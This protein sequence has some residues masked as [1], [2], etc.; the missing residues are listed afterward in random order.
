LLSSMLSFT[1]SATVLV[2][3]VVS[4]VTDLL[5]S[6][7]WSAVHNLL[8]NLSRQ[9]E[10]PFTVLKEAE[11]VELEPPPGIANPGFVI[12]CQGYPGTEHEL[13]SMSVR[14]TFV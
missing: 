4:S 9:Q 6:T 14:S 11:M 5:N 10:F 3:R 12:L 13:L 7:W 8:W 2:E 1:D